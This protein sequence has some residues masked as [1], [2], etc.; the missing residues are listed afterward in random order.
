MRAL[1]F[2]VYLAGCATED[3]RCGEAAEALETCHGIAAATFLEACNAAAPE[4]VTELVD[5]VLAG[6]CPSRDGK[7]DGLGE[8]LFI[9][10][11]QPVLMS[12]QLVNQVRNPRQAPLADDLK[13]RLR[14]RFGALVDRVKLHWN[15]TLPDDWPMLH[16]KDA[17]MDVGAQ[18]FGSH[19]FVASPSTSPSLTTLAHELVHARQAERLGGTLGFYRAYCRAFYR[20][21][22]SYANNELELEAYAEEAR[23]AP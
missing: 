15:A 14:P 3:A 8:A 16:V 11:C 1:A 2:V 22:F 17:F 12:A 20:A 7:A 5:T 6:S 23:L 18:T 19:I 10:V 13:A 9:E 4:E 21:G